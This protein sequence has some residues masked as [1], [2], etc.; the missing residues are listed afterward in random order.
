MEADLFRDTISNQIFIVF[1]DTSCKG[2]RI[3][4][5]CE[6]EIAEIYF[7]MWLP[8]VGY[9]CNFPDF[10]K[11]WDISEEGCKV[12]VEGLMYDPCNGSGNA[13]KIYADYILT[14]LKRK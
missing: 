12:E 6:T 1:S 11:K 3:V 8:I 13:D 7:F 10:V 9:V 4:F 5:D 2:C 14:R